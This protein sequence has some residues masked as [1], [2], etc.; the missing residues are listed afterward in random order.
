MATCNVKGVTH[1]DEAR[2]NNHLCSTSVQALLSWF[3][4]TTLTAVLSCR[5]AV[6]SKK[7]LNKNHCTLIVQHLTADKVIYSLINTVEHL[8]ESDIY[9]RSW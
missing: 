8:K 7:R 1:I 5:T 9:L 6:F 3:T 2:E 4:L